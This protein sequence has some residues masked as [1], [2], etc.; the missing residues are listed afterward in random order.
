MTFNSSIVDNVFAT[1]CG[2]ND[3]EFP[4]PFPPSSVNPG[5]ISDSY[6]LTHQY[7]GNGETLVSTY[8]HITPRVGK[9]GPGQVVAVGQMHIASFMASLVVKPEHLAEIKDFCDAHFGPGVYQGDMWEKIVAGGGKIPMRIKAVPEGT[10]VPRGTAIMVVESTTV[11][12]AVPFFEAQLQRIWYPTSVATR[13]TEYRAIVHKWLN[14]TT[15]PDLIPLIFSSRI[16]DFGARACVAE[17]G[18]EIGGMAAIEAGLGGSDTVAGVVHVMKLMPDIDPATGKAK[19]PAFSVAAGEHNVAMSRGKDGEM[20]PFEIA[21]DT[22]PTGILSWPIDTYNTLEFVDAVTL[23]GTLRA[24]LMSRAAFGA[25]KG[26]FTLTVLR[27]DSPVLNADGTKMS[28][29]QTLCAIF[30]RARVNLSD[31]TPETGGVSVNSKG[32]FVLPSWLKVIY[33]D[34]VTTDDVEDIYTQL[35]SD[36]NKWSAENIVFGVGGNLLQNGVTRGW[37]DFAMKCSQQTYRKDDTGE[38]IVRNV[39]KMTP[40][41]VSP[42]GRQKVITRGGQIMMVPEADGPEPDMM[43]VYYEDGR[44]YNFEPLQTVRDRVTFGVGF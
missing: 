10:V 20:I 4:N 24:R 31:L 6:K 18:A 42:V 33:G 30:A 27:P 26:L 11:P 35:A 23:P 37:L 39:G 15:N 8:A 22:Y 13:A 1:Q 9:S 25:S 5:L 7:N 28:H 29:A 36:G 14:N 16:H 19:M 17:G 41:K 21:L 2:S 12:E 40:G 44:L 32:Y 43:V 3:A 34:S 38:L